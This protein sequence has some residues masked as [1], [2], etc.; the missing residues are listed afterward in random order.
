MEVLE[1]FEFDESA[2]C[3]AAY[4]WEVWTD[5]L[6]RKVVKGVDY[7]CST[8][9]FVQGIYSYGKRHNM[10]PTTHRNGDTVVFKFEALT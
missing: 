4:P 9:S 1:N 6:T 2:T 10:K 3:K 7:E 5:G 8:A